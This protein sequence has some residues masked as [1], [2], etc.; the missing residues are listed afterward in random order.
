MLMLN[1][2]T[3]ADRYVAVWNEKDAEARRRAIAALWVLDGQHYM[4]GREARGYPALEERVVGSHNKYVR[5]GGNI[6]RAVQ[7]A[8]RVHNAVTF[9]W[10]MVPVG[11]ETVLAKGLEFLIVDRDGRVLID[12]M[13]SVA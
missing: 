5:D 13:F 3:L 1:A 4:D 8:R 9:N 12:Y 7:N 6:F 11:G 2:Q 10:E